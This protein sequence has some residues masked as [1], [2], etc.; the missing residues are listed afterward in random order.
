[1]SLVRTE[2]QRANLSMSEV[3]RRAKMHLPTLW[4]IEHGQRKLKVDEIA[5]LARAIGCKPSDLIPDITPDNDPEV[6]PLAREE[7]THA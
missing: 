3:A 1:M 2:R 4:K 5:L 6:P 7:V